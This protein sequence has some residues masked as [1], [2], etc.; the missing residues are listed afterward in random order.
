M[1][2]LLQQMGVFFKRR[3]AI[4]ADTFTSG[5]TKQNRTV[6]TDPQFPVIGVVGNG[7]QEFFLVVQFA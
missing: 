1:D 5:R 2:D 6:V 4:S 7:M 3:P